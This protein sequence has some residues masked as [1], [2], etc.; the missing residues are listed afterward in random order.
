MNKVTISVAIVLVILLLTVTGCTS[1]AG[2]TQAPPRTPTPS[3]SPQQTPPSAPVNL[4][5]NAVSQSTVSIQWLDN[6]NNEDGFRIY[7]GTSLVGTVGTNVQNYQDAGLQQGT[8]YQY[9][10]KA[11]NQAGESPAAVYTVTTPAPPSAPSNLTAGEI[12]QSGIQLQWIDNSDNE[13]GFMIYRGS[14]LIASVAVNMNAYQDTGLQPA[15][16]YQYAVIAYNQV[17]ESQASTNTVKT[18]N[19]PITIRLDRIGV[20]DN[21]EPWL[22]GNGDVYVLVGVVD[23]NNSIQLKFPS[24]QDQTYSLDKDETVSIGAIIYSASEVGDSLTIAFQGYESDG[25]NFEQLAY[26]ALGMALYGYIP[27]GSTLLQLFSINL[28]DLIGNLLGQEHDWLGSYELTGN[29]INN[30]GIDVVLKDERGV[31]C[32]RLWF[33]IESQG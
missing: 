11:Y 19:P 33:T 25:G 10:V 24:G 9:A 14:A 16:T 13:D 32:L 7:R 1:K 30:W 12:S 4:T 8:T 29:Q 20:Y 23:G 5:T 6:S 28:G 26:E 3:A 21:R 15:T 18:L 22:R 2:P 27:G 31:D 17:G